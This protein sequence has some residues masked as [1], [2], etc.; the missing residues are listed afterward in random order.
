[1]NG[2]EIGKI[3]RAEFGIGGYQ[4][5]MI[6]ISFDFTGPG[7]GVG[8][9]WGAWSGECSPFSQW[10]EEDR[11]KKLGGLV[12][13]LARILIEANVRTVRQ[14]EGKPVEVTFEDNT[15]KSWRILT[16]AI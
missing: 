5:A 1:M 4:D 14:L 12:M 15:L 2:K 11:I 8:D 9:F 10:T 7:W 3:K 13:R 6:G 16:E